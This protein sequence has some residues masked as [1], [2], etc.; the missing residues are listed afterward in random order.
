LGDSAGVGE[1]GELHI[2]MASV[3]GRACGFSRDRVCLTRPTKPRTTNELQAV[4]VAHSTDESCES[5][6]REGATKRTLFSGKQRN[7]LE[8][9][10]FENRTGKNKATVTGTP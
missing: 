9:G 2:D 10:I 6:G 7:T 5:R 3:P 4:G 8:V 1:H